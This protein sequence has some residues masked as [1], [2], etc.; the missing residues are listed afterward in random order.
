M[1][2]FTNS[3]VITTHWVLVATDPVDV[4]VGMATEVPE[5]DAWSHAAMAATDNAIHLGWMCSCGSGCKP[6]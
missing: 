4:L 1:A 6:C 3:P 2:L 5:L